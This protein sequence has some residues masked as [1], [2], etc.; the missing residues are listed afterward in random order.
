MQMQDAE[1]EAGH[2]TRCFYGFAGVR[3]GFSGPGIIDRL[4]YPDPLR[5]DDGACW[6]SLGATGG[7]VELRGGN[8]LKVFYVEPGGIPAGNPPFGWESDW[9]A[10][11]VDAKVRV[12]AVCA[13]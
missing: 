9:F 4:V 6:R 2:E 11:E 13:S 10:S 3:L 1:V 8:A 12:Y 5:C 7:G